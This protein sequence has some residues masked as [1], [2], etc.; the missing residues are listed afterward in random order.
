MNRRVLLEGGDDRF[1]GRPVVGGLD[2]G[3]DPLRRPRHVKLDVHRQ[4]VPPDPTDHLHAA[5]P[6]RQRQRQ[7]PRVERAEALPTPRRQ[8]MEY[9]FSVSRI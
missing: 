3:P 8:I 5:G 4:L 9:I 6:A 1:E 7:A 2:G